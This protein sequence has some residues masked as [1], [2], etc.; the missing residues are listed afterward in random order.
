[1]TC[2]ALNMPNDTIDLIKPFFPTS[3]CESQF[4]TPINTLTKVVQW[5]PALRP[6]LVITA[7]FFGRLVFQTFFFSLKR[8]QTRISFQL[9]LRCLLAQFGGRWF[10]IV[11]VFFFLAKMSLSHYKNLTN[12]GSRAW[13]SFGMRT[14]GTDHSSVE[15]PACKVWLFRQ[16]RRATWLFCNIAAE[17]VKKRC[18]VCYHPPVLQQMGLLQ[19]VKSYCK[20]ERV[21]VLFT[22]ISVHV[23]CFTGPRQTCFKESDLTPVYG[24]TPA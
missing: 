19:V 9:L 17:R 11:G 16:Q 12:T 15:V 14:Q 8:F 21:L 23:A 5:N 7:T 13:K 24:V 3:R 4:L 2:I 1:M 18:C 10:V 22:T 20:K 6:P